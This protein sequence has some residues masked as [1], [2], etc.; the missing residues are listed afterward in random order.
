MQVVNNLKNGS[1][2][3]KNFSQHVYHPDPKDPKVVNWIFVIDALNFC[4]WKDSED[5]KWK[6]NGETGYFALCAAIKRA[7]QVRK[8][9]QIF[10]LKNICL[11]FYFILGKHSYNG[12]IISV[13]SYSS[14]V[15]KDFTW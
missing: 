1:L 11:F 14:R 6:V 3:V 8:Q 4:F 10:E 12:C 13:R 5:L 7:T 9:I 15:E 2:S